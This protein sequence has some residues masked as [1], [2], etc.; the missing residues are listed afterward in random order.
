MVLCNYGIKIVSGTLI[1]D[2]L[3]EMERIIKILYTLPTNSH[4][5]A[6]LSKIFIYGLWMQLRHPPASFPNEAGYQWRSADGFNNNIS[7]P[8]IGKAGQKYVQ[9]CPSKRPQ[10]GVSRVL[11]D[12]GRIFDELFGFESTLWLE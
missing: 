9:D 3:L 8:N 11:P 6:V 2:R 4:I 7:L 1:D 5:G 10:P 12:P